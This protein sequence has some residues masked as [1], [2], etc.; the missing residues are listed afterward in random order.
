M[1]RPTRVIVAVKDQIPVGKAQLRWDAETTLSDIAVLPQLQGQGIG[2]SLIAHGINLSLGEGKTIQGLD[3][4]TRNQRAL[5]LYT[6][7]GFY[8]QNSCDFWRIDIEQLKG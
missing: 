7:L 8:I 4:E 6:R 1:M 2:R 3:V 5:N